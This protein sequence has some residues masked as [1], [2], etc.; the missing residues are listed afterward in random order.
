MI[1]RAETILPSDV[2]RSLKSCLRREKKPI[3]KLQLRLMLENLTLAEEMKIPICQDTGSFTFFIGGSEN[4][5]FDLVGAINRA[6]E[7]A[8]REI[9]LRV[10]VADP[11]TRKPFS[12]NTGPLQPTIHL[13]PAERAELEIS[14]LIKGAGTEN[15]TRLFMLPPTAGARGIRQALVSTLS[16]AGGKICPPVMV[17]LGIGGSPETALLLAKRTLLRR[18]DRKNPDRDLARLEAELEKTANALGIGPMGLGGGCTVLRVLIER[19]ACHTASLPVG[20]VFQCWPARRAKATLTRGRLEV[21]E[22]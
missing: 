21:V 5:G 22:P 11:L 13:E 6:V 4:L 19:A 17:G 1:R 18:L 16:E 9:P 7:R 2:V 15:Y 12:V 8:T 14:L 3:A 20:V 10:N